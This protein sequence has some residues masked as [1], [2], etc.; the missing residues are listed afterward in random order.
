MTQT[1]H[2]SIRD[3]VAALY[4]AGTPLCPRILENREISLPVGVESQVQV[5]RTL[6]DP[7]RGPIQG[8]PVD[9][10]TQI[11]TVIKARKTANGSAE[12]I[13]DAMHADAYARLMADQTLGGEVMDCVPGPIAWEQDAI[14]PDVAQVTFDVNYLHRTTANSLTT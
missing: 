14:D 13:A 6:S 5:Y 7:E 9:W 2:L 4:Q 11:R 10:T 8:S 1:L 12:T 3:A